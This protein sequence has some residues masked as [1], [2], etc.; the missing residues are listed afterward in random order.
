ML[1]YALAPI[2]VFYGDIAGI[3][4]TAPGFARN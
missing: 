4:A 3:R 1:E 2:Y